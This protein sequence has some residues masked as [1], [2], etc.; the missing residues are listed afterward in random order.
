MS[1]HA[2]VDFSFLNSE[3]GLSTLTLRTGFVNS[4]TT[5]WV[6]QLLNSELGLSTLRTGLVN[7]KTQNGVGQ[8]LKSELGL[9][10]L[11]LRT[12]SVNSKTQN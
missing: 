9:S 5:I 4:K 10:T 6:C 2:K 12:R 7:S 3:L 1:F 8:L 11:K